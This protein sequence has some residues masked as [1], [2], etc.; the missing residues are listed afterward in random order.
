MSVLRLQQLKRQLIGRIIPDTNG[1]SSK[2]ET[3][4]L[5]V[6]EYDLN[7]QT[8][9]NHSFL[10]NHSSNHRL[11]G[12]TY[13][14]FYIILPSTHISFLP[15][16]SSEKLDRESECN[17]EEE[18]PYIT[19]ATQTLLDTVTSLRLSISKGK[20]D[21]H[22]KGQYL[23]ATEYKVARNTSINMNM[24]SLIPRAFIFTGPPGGGKTF[25]VQM[26]VK[27][28]NN[29]TRLMS[30]RGSELLASGQPSRGL[31]STFQSALSY[32]HENK[33]T[34]AIIFMDEFDALLSSDDLGH[35]LGAILDQMSSLVNFDLLGNKD[36]FSQSWRQIIV[37]AATNKID[38]VPNYLRRPGRFDQEISVNAPDTFARSVIL[39]SLLLPY[40]FSCHQEDNKL[41]NQRNRVHRD[42][43]GTESYTESRIPYANQGHLQVSSDQMLGDDYN[44]TQRDLL[45]F[46][47]E[48]M[49]SKNNIT[50][51][52][53]DDTSGLS[54][55]AEACVGY[56][57]A[58]LTSLVRKAASLAAESESGIL[59]TIHLER[60]MNDVTASALRAAAAATMPKTSW[61]DIID[62][63]GA[64]VCSSPKQTI[65]PYICTS[66]HNQ[67]FPRLPFSVQWNGPEQ[68]RKLLQVWVLSHP[69]E[70]VLF[71]FP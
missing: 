24:G 42:L 8:I 66:I 47:T 61:D 34:V 1:V 40:R 49:N 14:V 62:L 6:S 58:D 48:K 27:I 30:I 54:M 70:Y 4:F 2:I 33:D 41:P 51:S 60:A 64:K 3:I 44:L 50:V 52:A 5:D 17:I 16:E 46:K 12:S 32:C 29:A 39:K 63:G 10:V 45:N 23:G 53:Y 31:I 11:E 28:I 20:P 9:H 7:S 19:K 55:I 36:D 21:S 22:L 15:P 56:V 25:S 43:V 69:E 57:P 68:K 37:V 67:S 71:P 35:L 26:A 13:S 38:T 65:S 59:N 18:T